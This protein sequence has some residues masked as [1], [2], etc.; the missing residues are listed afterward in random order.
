[1][2]LGHRESQILNPDLT[3]WATHAASFFYFGSTV[4][5]SRI[6][7]VIFWLALLFLLWK[8]IGRCRP[9]VLCAAII[10]GVSLYAL[11]G[12]P[13]MIS[14][15]G[16]RSRY[17]LIPYTLLVIAACMGLVGHRKAGALALFCIGG[18]YF[19]GK[20]K[21]EQG[22]VH[23][24]AYGKLAAYEDNLS[25]PVM[26][27]LEDA[28]GYAIRVR[29][30]NPI[31]QESTDYLPPLV[32]SVGGNYRVASQ[33]CATS[34]SLGLVS[35]VRREHSGIAKLLWRAEGEQAF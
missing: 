24:A 31:L 13:Q 6:L 35:V 26:P 4:V 21:V 18:V 9:V 33:A 29:Q 27:Q 10:Y 15:L 14:P 19:L 25:I 3:D 23:F 17:F 7:A 12:M 16:G 34:T 32:T 28:A 30:A 8:D 1:M 5:Y 20:D 22:H 11:K 2:L